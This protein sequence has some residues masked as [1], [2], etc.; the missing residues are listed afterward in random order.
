MGWD[1]RQ[2]AGTAWATRPIYVRAWQEWVVKVTP[3]QA[4]VVVAGTTAGG[5]SSRSG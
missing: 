5:S 1:A 2:L 3:C 4:A